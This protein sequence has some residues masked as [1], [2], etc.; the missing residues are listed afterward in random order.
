[1]GAEGPLPCIDAHAGCALMCL[2]CG[3]AD[4]DGVDVDVYSRNILGCSDDE[5]GLVDAGGDEGTQVQVL[6]NV[7]AGLV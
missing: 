2:L 3:D 4:G 5:H 1:M 6:D 7:G